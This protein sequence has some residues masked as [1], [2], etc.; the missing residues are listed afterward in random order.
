MAHL[1]CYVVI[2]EL[3][4]CTDGYMYHRPRSSLCHQPLGPD[5]RQLPLR[6]KGQYHSKSKEDPMAG[7]H[8]NSNRAAARILYFFPVLNDTKGRKLKDPMKQEATK[9]LSLAFAKSLSKF[10]KLVIMTA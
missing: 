4:G 3:T 8:W 5:G 1:P 9:Q 7:M 2:Q 10:F 6:S